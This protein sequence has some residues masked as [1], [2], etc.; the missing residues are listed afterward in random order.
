MN[1]YG[2]VEEMIPKRAKYDD[3]CAFNCELCMFEDLLQD[4]V[5]ADISRCI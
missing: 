4:W 2:F 3:K 1:A 5:P